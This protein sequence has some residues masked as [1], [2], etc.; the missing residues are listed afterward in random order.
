M[1][2]PSLVYVVNGDKIQKST[3][4]TGISSTP[5]QN[6]SSPFG[7]YTGSTSHL[8]PQP[9]LVHCQKSKTFCKIMALVSLSAPNPNKPST[10]KASGHLEYKII[11]QVVVTLAVWSEHSSS[12]A[13]CISSDFA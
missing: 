13:S 10:S 3:V 8:P 4:D 2:D 12:S 11:T 6:I 1:I 5:T 9:Q 7:A